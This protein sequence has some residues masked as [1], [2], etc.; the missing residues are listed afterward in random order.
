MFN[1]K[2]K[3]FAGLAAL[4]CATA[5]LAQDSG[6]LIDLLVK[7]GIINDQEG[8]DLR[9]E[10][11]KDFA[12]SPA[13]KLNLSAAMSE[14]K[15]A[16]D[17]RV[18]Y[19]SRTGELA[20]GD[21]QERDRFRYRFRAGLSGK[22]ASNWS[23]GVRLETATGS[24]SSN[25]TMGDDAGPFAKT[26][27]AVNVGQIWAQWTPT[28]EWTFTGGRMPNPLVTTAMT[29]DADINPEG[30]AESFKRRIGTVE[31]S[32]TAAQFLYSA[33]STQNAFGATPNVHD[34]FLLAWQGGIKFFPTESATKFLQINP[35]VYQYAHND[36]YNP[37][38]FKGTFTA[39]NA[40][41]VNNL[42]VVDVPVEYDWVAATG[43]P[44]RVF[45]DFAYNI[46]G[47]DRAAKWGRPDLDGE[48]TAWQ[49][50]LQY[51]KA[52]NKGEWDA[53]V[54]Y[55][56]VGAFALDPNLVDS[57]IFDSR[58][59]MQGFVFTGNYALGAATTFTLTLASGERKNDTL[60]APG[61]GDVGS[62]NALDKYL[63]LQADLV[64]KF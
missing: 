31:Y 53:K 49:V 26:S 51:G 1:L 3:V 7:K 57:D 34:L 41:A 45:G 15:L 27:D 6:P 19:E 14:L 59:N 8:E 9:A 10:L 16:G 39:A 25:V 36:N 40:A 55:Q 62:S 37:A 21:H 22:M 38:A 60:V 4:V 13:G 12:A 28:P 43:V 18:R 58:T 48:N 5:A 56:S 63:L 20:T 11:S 35:T 52:A 64:I 29:W 2:S 30:F 46:D 24:R 50:G 33:A 44:V 47:D 32:A 17:V 23:W 54:A 42:T 61:A